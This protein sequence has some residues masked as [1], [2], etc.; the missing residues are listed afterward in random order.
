MIVRLLRSKYLLLFLFSMVLFFLFKEDNYVIYLLIMIFITA[1]TTHRVSD[2]MAARLVRVV[3]LYWLFT[4][5]AVCALA[6]VPH[7]FDHSSFKLHHVIASYAFV[8]ALSPAVDLP[9]PGPGS[10][11]RGGMSEQRQGAPVARL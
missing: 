11:C 8:P 2:F 6:F 10:A 5:L 1:D 4:S 7:A 9:R 3:P